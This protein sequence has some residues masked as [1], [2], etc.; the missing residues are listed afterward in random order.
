MRI[1]SDIDEA[2]KRLSGLLLNYAEKTQAEVDRVMFRQ[3][4]ELKT[5]IQI[6]WPV[7]TGRSRAAWE[8]PIK[9]GYA[10]YELLN[11]ISYAPI[12][13]YGGYPRTGPKTAE[14]GGTELDGGVGIN[15]GIY[16]TQVPQAPARR[17]LAA[18]IVEIKSELAKVLKD[19]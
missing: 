9:R 19:V 17:A 6:G 2:A 13:E 1:T 3:A 10:D 7:D 12:I 16:P 4:A 11:S 18:K 5:A 8:G 14:F 15:A